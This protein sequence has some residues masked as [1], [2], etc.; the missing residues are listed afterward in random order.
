MGLLKSVVSG[1]KE[2][3]FESQENIIR[4]ISVVKVISE[5]GRLY[6]EERLSCAPTNNTNWYANDYT[7]ASLFW[8]SPTKARIKGTVTRPEYRG[9]GYG[10]TMLHYLINKVQEKANELGQSIN[11]ESYARNPKW[12]LAN[13]FTQSRITPW[14]VTVVE[15]QVN[16]I[17]SN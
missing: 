14:G 12:Y 10:S 4:E 15:M 8:R 6:K 1:R 17:G 16:P 2:V 9:F 3:M 11:L 7:C 5:W 13:G